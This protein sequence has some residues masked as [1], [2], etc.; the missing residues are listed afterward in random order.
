MKL[1]EKDLS[2][3]KEI[4]TNDDLYGDS[5]NNS[6]IDK[7]KIA[8]REMAKYKNEQIKEAI[9]DILNYYQCKASQDLP[10]STKSLYLNNFKVIQGAMNLLKQ[11]LGIN[12]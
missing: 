11:K 1:T 4:A 7:C 6:M 12:D 8:A 3:A 9:D 5:D 2:K 10:T